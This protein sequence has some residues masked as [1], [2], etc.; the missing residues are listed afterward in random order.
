MPGVRAGRIPLRRMDRIEFV[1]DVGNDAGRG[2]VWL[3]N[4]QIRDLGGE[5]PPAVQPTVNVTSRAPDG[6]PTVSRDGRVVTAWTTDASRPNGRLTLDLGNRGEIGGLSIDWDAGRFAKDFDILL[7]VDGQKWRTWYEVRDGAGGRNWIYL[8]D[9]E[10]RFVAVDMKRTEAGHGACMRTLRVLEPEFS[11]SRNDMYRM[12]A[13]ESPRGSYP[14]YYVPEQ[15]YW[16]VIGAPQ[17]RKEALMNEQG[18]IETDKLGFS[19]EPFMFVNGS[20]VTWADVSAVPTLE[21]EYMP[22]P[23]VRWEHRS[24]LQLTTSAFASGDAGKSVLLVRYRLTNVSATRAQGKLFVAARPFQVNPP[25]QTF[26]IHGGVSRVDSIRGGDRISINDRSVIPLTRPAAFGASTFD[27]GDVTVFLRMGVVPP[28][29]SVNDPQGLSSAALQYEFD[30]AANQTSDVVLAVPFHEYADGAWTGMTSS[31]AGRFYDWARSE[32]ARHWEEKLTHVRFRLPADEQK[33]AN[34]LRSSL[35][36]VLVNADSVG[37]QPGSRSYERS[38]IRDGALTATAMLQ[39]G[40]TREVREYIDWYSQYQYPNGA[41][42]CIVETRGADPVPEHDSHGQFIYMVGQYFRFTKDTAWLRTRWDNVLRAARHI[43]SLRAQRKTHPYRTGTPVQRACY[44]LVPESISHEGY[45]PRPMHS[46]WDNF[47]SIRGIKDAAALAGALGEKVIE[48]EMAAELNDYRA[49]LSNSIVASAALKG[50]NVI[51]GCVELGDVGGMSTTVAVTPAD[52]LGHLPEPLTRNSFDTYFA[53]WSARE[54]HPPPGAA[55]LPYEARFIGAYVY[56]GQ[57]DRAVAFMDHLLA[58]RRP[59]AWN[60]WAE[61]VWYDSLAPRN[62]GDMPHTWVASDFIRSVRAMF[63]YER[64][65]DT[66]LVIGGG[67]PARWLDDPAGV[68]VEGLPTYYGPLDFTMRREGEKT[69]VEIGGGIS[70]PPGGIVVLPPPGPDVP[71]LD[72]PGL[73]VR[74]LGDARRSGVGTQAIIRQVPARVEIGPK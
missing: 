50:L 26:T 2:V 44:G 32:A 63:A 5:A 73:D 11:F 48:R 7:S 4:F 6:N 30:L 35:G 65:V 71:G 18:M 15:S 3:D 21:E 64:E 1:V 43:Q 47:F 13:A 41:I 27:Q 46:Y 33:I 29:G 59:A 70:L 55:Y 14:R 19:L 25:W 57:R 24:G 66:S 22:M 38:W 23:S 69:V 54:N 10:A 12:I 72:V 16:T 49:A 17:D 42:P 31:E 56:L 37:T 62:I 45:S 51:P 34:T 58:D 74:H 8:P 39:M 36:Y 52:E 28:S 67:I 68:G 9:A 20:L 60:Q 61:V 53:E 40:L